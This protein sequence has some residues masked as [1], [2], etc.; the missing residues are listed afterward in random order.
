MT[1]KISESLLECDQDVTI[2]AHLKEI[3][4]DTHYDKIRLFLKQDEM[5]FPKKASQLDIELA[6]MLE[7]S[8]VDYS[9]LGDVV[10]SAEEMKRNY[11]TLPHQKSP[12][13][14]IDELEASEPTEKSLILMP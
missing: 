9:E 7:N 13:N 11:G 2:K 14:I 6:K 3:L 1:G 5:F 8:S 4:S 12:I 10:E